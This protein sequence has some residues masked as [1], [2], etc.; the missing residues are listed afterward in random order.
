MGLKSDLKSVINDNEI[1]DFLNKYLIT[2]FHRFSSKDDKNS[3]NIKNI[4]INAI[5]KYETLI[6]ELEYVRNLSISKLKLDDEM[7][8]EQQINNKKCCY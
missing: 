5:K 3:N 8:E 6:E 2:S 4:L 7:T 1:Y